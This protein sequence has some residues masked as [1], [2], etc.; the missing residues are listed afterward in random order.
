MCPR[1]AI[2][3][4]RIMSLDTLRTVVARLDPADVFRVVVA[5]YGEPTTHP[6][7]EE[8]LETLRTARVRVDMVTNGQLLD[9]ERLARL[10]GLLHTLIV[11]YSSIDPE[12][13]ARVH[14][15][16]GHERVTRNIVTAQQ[17]LRRTRL[18]VSLT[19]L[20][21]CLPS[22]PRTVAWLRSGGVTGLTMSPT[23]YDRAGSMAPAAAGQGPVD[24]RRVM[25]EHG[26]RSQEFDFVPSLRDIVAQWLVNRHRCIPRNTDLAIAAD[27]SYQYCFN[28]I[29]HSHVLGH[30]AA[31]TIRE[32]LRVREREDADPQLCGNCGVRRRYRPA[33]LGRA[34]LAYSA[35]RQAR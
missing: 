13:Y 2:V 18:A 8:C 19:P 24:L 7:F 21:I 32:A 3:N 11:S 6:R 34:L 20:S 29:R 12:V 27:G 23:L 10:D 14:V 16:L 5:G 26:L 25:R 17:R 4:P 31:M 22:L 1:E 9:E 30:V 33:E 35:R 28:D 15:N